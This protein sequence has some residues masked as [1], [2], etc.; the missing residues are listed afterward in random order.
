ME[1][2]LTDF[3]KENKK[4]VEVEELVKQVKMPA[5]ITQEMA[6]MDLVLL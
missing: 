6:E 1:T 3:H 5:D 4:L 2:V